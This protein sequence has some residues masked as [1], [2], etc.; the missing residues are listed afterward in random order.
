MTQIAFPWDSDEK[1]KKVMDLVS[2]LQF[3]KTRSLSNN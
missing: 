1:S 3:I 2:K